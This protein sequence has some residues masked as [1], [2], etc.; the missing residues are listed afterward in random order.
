MNTFRIGKAVT[1]AEVL[2]KRST[3]KGSCE[4][5]LPTRERDQIT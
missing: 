5:D 3:S 4:V 2:P 1:S